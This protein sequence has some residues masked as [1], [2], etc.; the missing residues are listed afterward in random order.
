MP[1]AVTPPAAP[2]EKSLA[3]PKTSYQP[4]QTTMAEQKRK[5][6]CFSGESL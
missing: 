2:L 4:T 5:I 1:A 6:I 3:I